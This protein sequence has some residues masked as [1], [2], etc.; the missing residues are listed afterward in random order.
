MSLRT[1]TATTLRRAAARLD[2]P[3]IKVAPPPGAAKRPARPAKGAKRAQ[4]QPPIRTSTS[5]PGSRVASMFFDEYPLFYET[6]QTT[7]T[8]GRLNLRYE[9]IFAENRD[10][11]EGATVLDIASHDGRWSHAALACGAKSVIGI[12]ARPDLVEH[13]VQT[14]GKYGW[15]PDRY[16]FVAGDIFEVFDKHEFDVDVVLC[17]GYLYHTMRYNELLHG[18]RK[19]NPRHLIIDTVSPAMMDS[20]LAAVLVKKENAVRESNAVTDD[21]SHGDKVLVGLPNLNAIRTM[22]QAYG[23]EVERLSDWDGLLRDNPE[24]EGVS[25]YARHIRVTLRCVD[26]KYLADSSTR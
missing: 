17:L 25:D 24:L 2:P 12:E 20:R 6:S 18:I 8:R 21:Y 23:F 1:R 11:F 16:R 7:P 14:L 5:L 15:G 3:T 26:E 4:S 9:A 19:A 10:I 22:V 13:S